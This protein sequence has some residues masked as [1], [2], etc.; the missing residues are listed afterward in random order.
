MSTFL[1]IIR[2]VK[3]CLVQIL[4]IIVHY[5]FRTLHN[6]LMWHVVKTMTPYL[7]DQFRDARSILTEAISGKKV[8]MRYIFEQRHQKTN[9]MAVG[10]AKTQISLGICP[11]WSVFA[12]HMKKDWVLSC[13]LSAQ[14][15]LWSDWADAQADLFAGRTLI[16][17]VLSCC[18]LIWRWYGQTLLIVSQSPQIQIKMIIASVA[19]IWPVSKPFNSPWLRP[20]IDFGHHVSG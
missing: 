15:R 5:I 17:L 12:V 13:L 1:G 9:K 18:G 7:S 19:G 3:T 8:R 6:Y 10:P 2:Y 16:L 14:W 20:W 11:V 4:R